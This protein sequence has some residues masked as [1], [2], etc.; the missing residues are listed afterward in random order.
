[1]HSATGRIR[2]VTLFFALG[3]SGVESR[4]Q[5]AKFVRTEADP[6]YSARLRSAPC[7]RVAE[8][9]SLDT[10]AAALTSDDAGT[11]CDTPPVSAPS[12]N[13]CNSSK[14]SNQGCIPFRDVVQE[15]LATLGKPGQKI[16]R[17]RDKI[18][19][20]LETD[21]A[22]TAWFREKDSNPA[23]TFRTIGFTLD[24]KGQEYVLEAL[25]SASREM[26][27]FPYVAKVI[28]GEGA[29]S[30]II[31]NKN[32]GFFYPMVPVQKGQRQLSGPGFLSQH[33]LR[34]GPY[35]GDTLSAQVL[36]L[37]HEFGH[38]LDRLPEDASDQGEQSAL[39]TNEVL[40]YCRAEIESSVKHATLP[41]R[42]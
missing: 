3:F 25:D 11:P 18:L 22:C 9:D 36:A 37:L 6:V 14:L 19:E 35:W 27:H 30:N 26:L 21:N 31:I 4:A 42:H 40:R 13:P 38:V 16:L 33:A 17:A 41:V 5:L 24:D 1:M 39:N 23:A 7:T 32:G 10:L 28:P 29:Y 12:V 2:A 20:M 34:V 15:N 8:R